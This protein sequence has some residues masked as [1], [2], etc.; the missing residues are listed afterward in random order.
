MAKEFGNRFSNSSQRM[1]GWDY[2]GNGFYFITIITQNR[3]CCLGKIEEDKVI[4]SD[5]GRIVEKEWLYSFDLRKELSLDQYVI[6]PNHI[7]AIVVL[8][9]GYL[10]LRDRHG[11][12]AKTNSQKTSDADKTK[13]AEM[14]DFAQEDLHSLNHVGT[15]RPY[16]PRIQN[17]SE[18][19]NPF[20]HLW[21]V[22]NLP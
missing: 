14:N 17:F 6:M 5:W 15:P 10:N 2:S 13:S 3:D 20:P 19:P 22:S 12:Q 7:H 1:P 8:D 18:N 21:L 11:H 9:K 16:N 4:L